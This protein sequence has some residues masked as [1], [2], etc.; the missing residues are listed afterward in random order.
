MDEAELSQ[1]AEDI[2]DK[3]TEISA[4][5]QHFGQALSELLTQP[6]PTVFEND[7]RNCSTSRYPFQPMTFDGNS[8][9]FS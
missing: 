8:A 2:Q 6:E 3:L 9:E 7:A 1:V 4:N 5:I